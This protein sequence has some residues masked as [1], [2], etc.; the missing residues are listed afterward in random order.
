MDVKTNKVVVDFSFFE[1]FCKASE[2]SVTDLKFI[3]LAY[4]GEEFSIFTEGQVSSVVARLHYPSKVKPFSAGV[5]AIKFIKAFKKLYAGDITIK[6]GKSK[7]E[8]TKDNIKIK[9]PIISGRSYFKVHEGFSLV[10]A[11]KDWIVS[12]LI[13]MLGTIEEMGKKGTEKFLGSLFETNE[14]VTRLVKFSQSAIYLSAG[15]PIFQQSYRVLIPDVLAHVAK[16]FPTSVEEIIIARTT[17]GFKLKH[18]VEVFSAIPYD[19]YPLEY[20]NILK[21]NNGVNMIPSELMGY[22]FQTEELLNAVDLVATTLGDAESWITL[23]TVGK[24][25]DSLV[26]KIGGK[27][28]NGVEVEEKVLSSKGSIVEPFSVNKK[29]MLKCLSSFGKELCL[30]DLSSSSLALSDS[31]GSKVALLTKA[32]V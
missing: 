15:A 18:G 16:A 8:I 14:S 2:K 11:P 27:A 13:S 4:D 31:S 25:E 3:Y 23:E 28:Y 22:N 26:W 17:I 6:F 21:L 30:H 5:E 10:D 19:T 1:E 20:I 24:S 29:R 7:V 12:N 9:F 32:A